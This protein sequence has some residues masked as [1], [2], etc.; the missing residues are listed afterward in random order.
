MPSV[1]EDTLF[2]KIHIP[3][4]EDAAA[5]ALLVSEFVSSLLPSPWLWNK[6]AWELKV[7]QDDG[8]GGPREA[9]R[10]QHKLSGTMRVGDAVDDEWL[11]VWLL[12]EVSRKWPEF[13][14]RYV[15]FYSGFGNW[16]VDH[17]RQK[18]N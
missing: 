2:Y 8:V 9:L 5:T 11:V 16:S 6:D 1:A 3:G 14:I 7:L 17:G 18:I 12:R 10:D 13:V 4:T 15:P